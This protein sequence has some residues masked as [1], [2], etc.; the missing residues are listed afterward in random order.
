M[1]RRVLL[2]EDEP[3]I[4]DAVAFALERDAYGVEVAADG[5]R[6]IARTAEREWDLVILDLALPD[7][8]GL[9]VC[10]QI[11]ARSAVPIIILTARDTEAD[12]VAGLEA[13]ADDYLGKPFSM[14]ELLARVRAQLRRQELD[15]R[16]G[17]LAVRRVGPL[18][19]D[20]AGREV[21]LGERLVHLTNAEFNLLLV[22]SEKPDQVVTKAEIVSRLWSTDFVGDTRICDT[23]VARLRK[24]LEPDP[25]HPT[26]IRTVRGQGYRLDAS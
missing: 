15:R 2:V 7:R 26:L 24:K 10:R 12:R 8:S 3:L 16:A 13:G 18:T 19:I 4:A 5:R 9:D 11:R 17:A 14:A 6:A 1:R 25:A 20:L 21:R 22:L 23:H